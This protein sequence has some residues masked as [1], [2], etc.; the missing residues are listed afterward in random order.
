MAETP[1]R[2]ILWA[3]SGTSNIAVEG[4]DS[5]K[6]CTAVLPGTIESASDTCYFEVIRSCE[7]VATD[8]TGSLAINMLMAVDV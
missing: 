4:K 6:A 2:Q 7:F 1:F 5:S 3:S 8:I